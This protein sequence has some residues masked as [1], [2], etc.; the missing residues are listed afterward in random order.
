MR[1]LL[2]TWFCLG[3]AFTGV[4]GAAHA[5]DLG[6]D[7]AVAHELTGSMLPAGDHAVAH[8]DTGMPDCPD[9]DTDHF[10]HCSAHA[11]AIASSLVD[12]V[13]SVGAIAPQASA[14]SFASRTPSV[15]LRP[16]NR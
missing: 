16:P 15:P 9:G 8:H 10:C 3:I 7:P 11:A 5:A 4:E 1:K 6:E 12:P 2:L 14:D 13:T